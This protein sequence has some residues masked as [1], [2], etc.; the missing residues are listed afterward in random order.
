MDAKKQERILKLCAELGHGNDVLA[1]LKHAM[2]MRTTLSVIGT[3][4]AF[5]PLDYRAVRETCISALTI[6]KGRRDVCSNLHSQ[7]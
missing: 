5:P 2:Q 4:A 6:D 7:L 3:W 1:A